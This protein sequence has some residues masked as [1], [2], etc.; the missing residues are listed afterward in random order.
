M[1]FLSRSASSRTKPP[2]GPS[3]FK[4]GTSRVE[5]RSKELSSYLLESESQSDDPSIKRTEPRDPGPRINK[6]PEKQRI[7]P[8]SVSDPL[9]DSKS[10][11]DTEDKITKSGLKESKSKSDLK[12]KISRLDD[13]EHPI[14]PIEKDFAQLVADNT[15]VKPIYRRPNKKLINRL[16]ISS[17]DSGRGSSI[18]SS[19]NSSASSKSNSL[20]RQCLDKVDSEKGKLSTEYQFHQLSRP[21]YLGETQKEEG[22]SE[23][24]PLPEEDESFSAQRFKDPMLDEIIFAEEIEEDCPL[25]DYYLGDRQNLGNG[26]SNHQHHPTTTTITEVIENPMFA[27]TLSLDEN[28]IHDGHPF[29]ARSPSVPIQK[30]FSAERSPI[31]EEL[32]LCHPIEK[33]FLD[34]IGTMKVDTPVK[35]AET[36]SLKRNPILKEVTSDDAYLKDSTPKGNSSRKE[37]LPKLDSEEISRAIRETISEAIK[38]VIKL[39]FSSGFL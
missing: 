9:I 10:K 34:N 19:S 11:S 37:D 4:G 2:S 3:S 31:H 1:N 32:Q 22:S 24:Y 8:P 25:S 7:D 14:D 23:N 29:I 21:L 5:N 39:L 20:H 18:G 30:R 12:D 27:T 6:N 35:R 17:S 15:F 28:E 33:R 13:D 36:D 16:S 38:R 26:L